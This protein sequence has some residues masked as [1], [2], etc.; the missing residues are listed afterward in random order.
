MQKGTI[1]LPD[2]NEEPLA[3]T[4]KTTPDGTLSGLNGKSDAAKSPLI[5]DPENTAVLA[6][7]GRTRENLDDVVIPIVRKISTTD[8]VR[9]SSE[10]RLLE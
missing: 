2:T 1:V 8:V 9:K 7:A 4:M 5:Y 6:L 3:K 10:S